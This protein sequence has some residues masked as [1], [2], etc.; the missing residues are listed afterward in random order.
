MGTVSGDPST[1]VIG[2]LTAAA[3]TIAAYA[4]HIQRGRPSM[5]STAQNTAATA[6]SCQT[7]AGTAHQEAG[8]VCPARLSAF[9]AISVTPSAS[10]RITGPRDSVV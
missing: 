10:A 6:T 7:N 9:A 3:A 4:A 8:S 2:T 1:R 5:R